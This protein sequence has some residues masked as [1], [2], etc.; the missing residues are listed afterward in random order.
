MTKYHFFFSIDLQCDS[1]VICLLCRYTTW[2]CKGAVNQKVTTPTPHSTD[3]LLLNHEGRIE[4]LFIS[5]VSCPLLRSH[6]PETKMENAWGSFPARLD[7]PSTA[8]TI[9]SLFSPLDMVFQPVGWK[10][11]WSSYPCF[12]QPADSMKAFEHISSLPCPIKY[13]RQ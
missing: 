7:T 3:F 13:Q 11:Q 12:L 2:W 4:V 10:L 9:T 6:H 1:H 5:A 8:D